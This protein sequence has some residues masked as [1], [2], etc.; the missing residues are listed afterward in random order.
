MI[1]K[2]SINDLEKLS[3]IKAHTLRAWEQRYGLIDPLRTDTNI[4]YY[5]DDHLKKILNVAVLVKSGMRISKVAEMTTD[6]IKAAVI[7]AGRYQGVIMRAKSIPLRLQCS[8]M[9]SICLTLFLI[10]ALFSSVQMRHY[11]RF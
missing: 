2:Y 5:V 3:G 7:D 8:I 10:S 6:E 9:M 11:L 4:R 1:S